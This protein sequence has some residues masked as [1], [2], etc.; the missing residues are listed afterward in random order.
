MAI[1]DSFEAAEGFPQCAKVINDIRDQSNC[2]WG[3]PL[4]KQ[5]HLS[6]KLRTPV[7]T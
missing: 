7:D 3:G 2:G 1:P 5:S 6:H 4:K